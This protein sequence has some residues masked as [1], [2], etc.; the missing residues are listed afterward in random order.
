M[1]LPAT[2]ALL[3][4]PAPEVPDTAYDPTHV[5]LCWIAGTG[6][7][8]WSYGLAV[9]FSIRDMLLRLGFTTSGTDPGDIQ[10]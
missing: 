2:R 8:L 4:P 9:W 3:P 10:Y 1:V 6:H 7:G 5:Y